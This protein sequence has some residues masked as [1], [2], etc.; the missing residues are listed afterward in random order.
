MHLPGP[1]VDQNLVL[2]SSSSV[3]ARSCQTL[4]EMRTKEGMKM[5][6]EGQ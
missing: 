6:G 4:A 2:Q 5:E 3:K 1:E